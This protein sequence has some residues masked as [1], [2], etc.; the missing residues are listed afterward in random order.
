MK[1]RIK[2]KFLGE[3]EPVFFIA[4]AGVN[5]NG[6]TEYAYKLI[7]IAVSSGADAVKFQTFKA[8]NLNTKEAPKSTYHIDTTGSDKEQSWFE[9]LKTQ[10]ISLQMHKDLI[11][12][13]SKKNIIFLSTPYDEES[14]DL[15]DSL[16]VPAFKMASTDTNNIPLLKHVA[17]KKKPMI[18]STA[19]C[20]FN[21]VK[22]AYNAIIEEGLTKIVI[23]QCTGNYPSRLKDSNINVI[24]TYKDN[25]DCVIGYSDHTQDYINPILA[26]GVGASVYEKHFTIDKKMPGPDHRMSLEPNELKKQ[27]SLLRKA[28][29]SMGNENKF[30]LDDEKENR[31]KLRKSVVAA[32]DININETISIEMLTIKRPG[33]GI[34]PK[35]IYNIVGKKAIKKIKK[36]TLLDNNCFS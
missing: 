4:E 13:C 14:A 31:I 21:E 25:F 33:N 8:E 36:D 5:H 9:L 15:L 20:D 30:I 17:R 18:I 12:Y 24:K 28:E 26:V 3:N 6:S 2:N 23:C 11:D 16:N 19:M 1:I 34:E 27:I 32:R 29:L 35:E 10:E 7:D 22:D